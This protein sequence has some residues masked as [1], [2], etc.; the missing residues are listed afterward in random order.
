MYICTN[1]QNITTAP[2]RGSELG[3]RQRMEQEGSAKRAKPSVINDIDERIEAKK[4]TSM[5]YY[6]RIC[7][8]RTSVHSQCMD[9]YTYNMSTYRP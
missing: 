2:T 5:L 9:A 6:V 7:Y 4:V 3:K 8:V 1:Q